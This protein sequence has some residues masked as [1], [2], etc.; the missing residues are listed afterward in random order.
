MIQIFQDFDISKVGFS[1]NIYK[2]KNKIPC[3]FYKI[4]DKSIF[5]KKNLKA[6]RKIWG[7]E[8]VILKP[9]SSITCIDELSMPELGRLIC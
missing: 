2:C 1:L 4:C 8:I 6:Y 5:K 7:N 3:F 9:Q